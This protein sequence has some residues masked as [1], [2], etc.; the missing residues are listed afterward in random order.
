MTYVVL[1]LIVACW[2]WIRYQ[3]FSDTAYVKQRIKGRSKEQAEVIRYFCNPGGCLKK[4]PMS[5][6]QYDQMLLSVLNSNDYKAK[7]LAK[8]GLDEEQVSLIEPV[9]FEGYIFSDNPDDNFTKLGKDGKY[10]SSKYQ[11][12]WL[13]FSDE[14]VYLYQNTFNMDEDGK[15]EATEEYFYTDITNF[16]TSSDTVETPFIDPKNLDKF[17]LKNVN[18]TRFALVVPGDK[19]YCSMEQNEYTE[20]AVQAMKQLLREKKKK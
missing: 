3:F 16:S 8:I 14:Q 15:K 4:S 1:I 20:N 13:F 6:E 18:S 12:S 5:D 19:F 9:H 2:L 17:V 11:V 10:R 7:G